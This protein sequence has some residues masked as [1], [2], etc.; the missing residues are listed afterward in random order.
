MG[1]HGEYPGGPGQERAEPGSATIGDSVPS[2]SVRTAVSPGSAISGAMSSRDLRL[3]RGRPRRR[4]PVGQAE[5]A[6]VFVWSVPSTT[7]TS[8]VATVATGVEVVSGC[9]DVAGR[10]SWLAMVVAGVFDPAA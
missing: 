10:W 5:L 9:T 2:K 6:V 7:T 1:Q 3:R 4:R 8:A